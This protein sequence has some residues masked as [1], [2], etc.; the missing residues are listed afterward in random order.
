MIRSEMYVLRLSKVGEDEMEVESMV[1]DM[2]MIHDK[3]KALLNHSI[4]EVSLLFDFI[5]TN[6]SNFLATLREKRHIIA[7]YFA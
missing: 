6:V 1:K 4:S 5:F 2:Y 3:S 7:K